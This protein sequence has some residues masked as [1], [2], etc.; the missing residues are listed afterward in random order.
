MTSFAAPCQK[1]TFLRLSNNSLQAWPDLATCTQ[2]TTLHLSKAFAS[3]EMTV[4]RNFSFAALTSASELRLLGLKLR[5][6]DVLAFQ[7]LMALKRLEV[8][9]PGL[10]A[11]GNVSL[12]KCLDEIHV[13]GTSATCLDIPFN[14]ASQGLVV[15]TQNPRL[16]AIGFL[17]QANSGVQLKNLDLSNNPMLTT[18]TTA[19]CSS[20]TSTA[21]VWWPGVD[22]VDISNTAIPYSPLFCDFVGSHSFLAQRMRG[23][24]AK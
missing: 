12:P 24:Y 19:P 20:S 23:D 22:N 4:A 16:K 15:I 9:S 5:P 8:G 17:G 21:P 6:A 14:L 3:P 1:M 2:L 18:V 7:G 11:L 13:E 10:T